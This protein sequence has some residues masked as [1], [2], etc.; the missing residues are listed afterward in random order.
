VIDTEQIDNLLPFG[1]INETLL[2]AT[3]DYI[4]GNTIKSAKS[5]LNMKVESIADSK[6][7]VPHSKEMYIKL[8][9]HN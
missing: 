1:D 3:L 9:F 5:T 2:K 8:K 6:D 4:N 7:F